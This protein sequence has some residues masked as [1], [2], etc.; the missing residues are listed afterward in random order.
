MPLTAAEQTF[1]ST[2][3]LS[4]KEGRN[5]RRVLPDGNSSLAR[6]KPPGERGDKQYQD[7]AAAQARHEF[8]RLQIE[9]RTARERVVITE[10]R[11]CVPDARHELDQLKN[12]PLHGADSVI[13]AVSRQQWFRNP[14]RSTVPSGSG[15]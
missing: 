14:R 6:C 12:E 7:D 2:R 13:C 4:A 5:S 11:I 9:L 3:K 1:E 15:C 10:L 8:P